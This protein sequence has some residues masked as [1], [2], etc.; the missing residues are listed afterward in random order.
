MTLFES[1]LLERRQE[2]LLGEMNYVGNIGIMELVSFYEQ[3]RKNN[4]SFTLKQVD[5]LIKRN[6][7]TKAWKIIQDYLGIKLSGKE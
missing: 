7:T 3:T 5:D 4:D 6:K 2:M 1:I